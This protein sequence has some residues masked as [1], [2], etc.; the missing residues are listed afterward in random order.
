MDLRSPFAN[1]TPS[2]RAGCSR[3]P[4]VPPIDIA[5]LAVNCQIIFAVNVDMN[6]QEGLE[7]PEISVVRSKKFGD[8]VADPNTFF[9]LRLLPVRDYSIV[10]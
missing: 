9:I 5:V 7:I 8:P 4:I 3:T 2:A 10:L 1:F 6:L